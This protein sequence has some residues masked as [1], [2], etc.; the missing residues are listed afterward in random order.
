[1]HRVSRK[2][3]QTFLAT[4]VDSS[5]EENLVPAEIDDFTIESVI[6]LKDCLY[7]SVVENEIE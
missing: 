6:N 4:L 3:D 2:E 7:L 5:P 1:M